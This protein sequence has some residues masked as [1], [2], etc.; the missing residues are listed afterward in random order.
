MN[1]N[2]NVID[3]TY[4]DVDWIYWQKNYSNIWINLFVNRPNRRQMII[5]I[6]NISDREL[7]KD[8]TSKRWPCNTVS[9]FR[10]VLNSEIT[11]E[12]IYFI[13]RW[14]VLHWAWCHSY[15]S[16]MFLM[17]WVHSRW[18]RHCCCSI[19]RYTVV[20]IQHGMAG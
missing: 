7:F 16:G 1:K 17:V 13:P 5:T 20:N 19:L 12:F 3:V 8:L 18:T 2:V 4:F 10:M 9:Q 11:Y 6:N 15:V 14:K